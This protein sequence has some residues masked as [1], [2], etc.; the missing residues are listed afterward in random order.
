V[1]ATIPGL[2]DVMEP[3]SPG[4]HRSDTVDVITIVSG[5]VVMALD[6][7]AEVTLHAGDV[8][9]QNGTRHAWF[10]RSHE[11]AVLGMTII[12]AARHG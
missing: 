12:G 2:L 6:D 4:F 11:P 7:G 3:A 10:N 9:M 5:E 8:V 1:S